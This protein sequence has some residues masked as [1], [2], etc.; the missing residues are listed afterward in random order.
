MIESAPSQE[1]KP[2]AKYD[3]HFLAIQMMENERN[4]NFDYCTPCNRQFSRPA[5]LERHLESAKTHQKSPKYFCEC[6]A[7]FGRKDVL[8][9]F[10]PNRFSRLI[11]FC[12]DIGR[13]AVIYI[14][15]DV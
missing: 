5:D 12:R 2:S 9:V 10:V 8:Q 4:E 15:N 13:K 11:L 3:D 7:E 1:H 14:G 6:G